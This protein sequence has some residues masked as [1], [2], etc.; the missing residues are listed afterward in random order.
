VLRNGQLSF[1]AG[2]PGG[3][4]IVSATLLAVLQWMRFGGDPQ[5]AINAPRI[6]HQWMPDLLY[7]EETLPAEVVRALEARGHTVKVR[8]WIG[9]VNAIGIDPVSGD[10]LGAADPRR[11]GAAAGLP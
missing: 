2:S 10:R 1:V 5:A 4:R 3:P 9:Q 6:H 7:V 8:T 11:A